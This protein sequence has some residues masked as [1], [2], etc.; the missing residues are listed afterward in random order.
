MDEP[1]QTVSVGHRMKAEFNIR[2]AIECVLRTH[3]ALAKKRGRNIPL[4]PQEVAD[5]LVLKD[6]ATKASKF[7]LRRCFCAS[8]YCKSPHKDKACIFDPRDLVKD[9]KLI[10]TCQYRG[11]EI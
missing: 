9:Q 10:M 5:I 7:A 6:F 3:D 4:S 11:K 8:V 2:T 1:Q